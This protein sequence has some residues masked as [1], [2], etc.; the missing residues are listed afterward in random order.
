MKSPRPGAFLLRIR[1]GQNVS[2][3]TLQP[4]RS[5]WLPPCGNKVG[6]SRLPALPSKNRRGEIF[7]RIEF[8]K[9]SDGGFSG[10]VPC[11]RAASL[12]RLLDCRATRKTPCR[13]AKRFSAVSWEG[14]YVALRRERNTHWSGIQGE[15]VLRLGRL[16]GGFG[17]AD[18]VADAVLLLPPSGG[19]GHPEP[20][21]LLH[22]AVDGGKQNAVIP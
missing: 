15:L 2:R 6:E 3:E 21:D 11:G 10:C 9:G 14:F 13:R 18:G 19:N 20:P 4:G 1:S 7:D 5:G 8:R 16:F 17:N 22:R 12:N